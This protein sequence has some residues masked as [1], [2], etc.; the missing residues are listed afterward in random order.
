MGGRGRPLG[1]RMCGYVRTQGGRWSLGV[2]ASTRWGNGLSSGRVTGRGPLWVVVRPAAAAGAQGRG[3]RGLVIV[4]RL[5][6]PG[7]G[8][9]GWAETRV[10][11]SVR[12]APRMVAPWGS[13]G[14]GRKRA[15]GCL[16]RGRPG[17]RKWPGSRSF[18]V[19]PG[20]WKPD[21]GQGGRLGLCSSLRPAGPC[22][23]L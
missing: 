12:T 21:G 19:G 11:M 4:W 2:C 10:A 1:A 7:C 22:P 13:G 20:R 5:V 23:D 9:G 8:C 3:A 14:V 15:P 16:P 6:S 18:E 17:Q